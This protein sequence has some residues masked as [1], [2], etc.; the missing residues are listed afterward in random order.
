M[1]PQRIVILGGTGFVGSH[2]VPRLHADGHS[3]KVLSRNREQHRALTVLPRVSVVTV[4][5]DDRAKLRA[6][7]AGPT[8]SSISSASST[9]AAA[10][11]ADSA[12]RTSS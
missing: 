2:L 10:T 7:I 9:S 8:R 11:A 12:R 4:D 3:I 1:K 6:A 5:V